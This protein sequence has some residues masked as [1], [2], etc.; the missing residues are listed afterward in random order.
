VATIHHGI[1]LS[2]FTPRERTG[3]GLVFLGRIHPDKGVAEAIAV[4]RAV[5]LPLVIAGL[6]QDRDYFADELAP[7]VDGERV[8]CVR[9]SRPSASAATAWSTTICGST[10]RCC[11][12]RTSLERELPRRRQL[13]ARVERD[14]LVA[15]IR[16]GRDRARLRADARVGWRPRSTVSVVGRLPAR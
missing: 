8:R 9:P 1:D 2:E 7:H 16:R 11:P 10:S 3:R 14:A 15:A 6:V 5:G 13:L 4:A 12:A